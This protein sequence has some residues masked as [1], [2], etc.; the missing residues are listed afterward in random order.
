MAVAV[1]GGRRGWVDPVDNVVAR[2]AEVIGAPTAVSGDGATVHAFPI[3]EFNAVLL[4]LT[5]ANAHLA[6]H[7]LLA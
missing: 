3:N 6:E 4:A 5:H 1:L 2:C 7:A